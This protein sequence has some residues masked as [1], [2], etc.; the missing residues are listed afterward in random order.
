MHVEQV[1]DLEQ[2][3][4]QPPHRHLRRRLADH[5]L[6]DRAQRLGEGLD[7]MFRRHVSGLEMHPADAVIV[8]AQ[9]APQDLRQIAPLGRTQPPDDAEID[10]RQLGRRMA[11]QIPL[12]QVGVEGP[13]VQRLG[14]EGPHHIVGQ[15]VAVQPRLV[16]GGRIGHGHARGPFQRQDPLADPVPDHRR[17]GHMAARRDVPVH[18]VLELGGGGGLQPHVQ[19]QPQGAGDGLDEGQGL[20]PPRQRHETHGDPRRQPHRIQSLGHPA[21]D[22]GAQHLDRHLAAVGQP[23]RMRLG[24]RRGGHR[25]TEIGEQALD[26]P[27]QRPFDLA[28]RLIDREGFQRVLQPTQI[29]REFQPEN[30][31]PGGQHLSQFDGHRPEMFERLAQPLA[32]PAVAPFLA[33]EG[34]QQMRQPA[35]PH[36]QQGGDLARRQGVVA[37]QNPA[38]AEQAQGRLDRMADRFGQR[39]R[40]RRLVVGGMGQIAHP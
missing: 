31:G 38:P 14:Q 19:L 40:G 2:L 8:A 1:G 17:R 29:A 3:A 13:V 32:G 20:Q 12:M 36:R 28:P 15:G 25:R 34:V 22:A 35:N 23:G 9:E 27:A 11:E 18:D 33:G 24:Q 5:R 39:R 21:L 10:R 30:V 16:G 6:A 4:Q 37:H 7:R 26:R